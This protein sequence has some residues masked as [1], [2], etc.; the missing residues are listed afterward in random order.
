MATAEYV[1][2]VQNKTGKTHNYLFFNQE[3]GE[4]STVGQIYTNVWIRSPGVPSP[5]GKAV[6][7][8]KVANFAICGTTPDP[9][10]YGVV[11]STS[12]FAP[13]ELTTKDKK[14]TL[15]APYEETDKDNSFGIHVKNYDPKRYST[16]YCGFG[17][18]NQKEEVVPVAVW[19][20]EPGEK[21]ILTPKVTY[22]V[23]TGDYKAGET[24][25]VTQ[26][27]EVSTIDFTKAKPGQTVATIT[28]NDDGSYSNPEFGYP[29]KR[30]PYA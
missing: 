20:A 3:P 11:V 14:G 9:V 7:D 26:I 5:R 23:S 2:T 21:Y 27:G 17:K 19:R 22:Y 4:S 1:I 15:I 25:D 8:V 10:H 6:F 18:L 28:H 12:D 30:K 29:E 13:V 24:V 16:V